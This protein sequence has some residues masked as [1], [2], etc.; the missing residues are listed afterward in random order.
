MLILKNTEN[1]ISLFYAAVSNDIKTIELLTEN[2]AD[3]TIM[4]DS[5][6]YFDDYLT[7]ENDENDEE[8]KTELYKKYPEQYKNLLIAK[9]SKKYNL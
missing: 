4:D 3:W 9:D 5:G 1:R 7:G 2:D 8:I 6:Y